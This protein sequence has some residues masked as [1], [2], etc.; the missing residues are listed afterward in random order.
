MELIFFF[1]CCSFSAKPWGHTDSERATLLIF[2]A[3][4]FLDFSS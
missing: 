4:I 2:E 1:I 3:D